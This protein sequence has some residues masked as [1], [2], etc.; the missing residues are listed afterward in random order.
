[1]AFADSFAE[2]FNAGL[3]RGLTQYNVAQEER[4]RKEQAAREAEAHALRMEEAR[5]EAAR[6]RRVEE[7]RGAI[8]TAAMQGMPTG[9]VPALGEATTA[10]TYLG[11][12]GYGQGLPA[13]QEMA[14]DYQREMGRFG[15]PQQA[16]QYDTAGVGVRQATD[17][18]INRLTQQYALAANDVNAF[19]ALRGEAADMDWKDAFGERLKAFRTMT[20][21][22][23]KARM[24][25]LTADQTLPGVLEWEPGKTDKDNKYF[26]LTPDRSMRV[27]LS[28][29]EVAQLSALEEMAQVDPVRAEQEIANLTGK[30]REVG[31][32]V[33]ELLNQQVNINNRAAGDVADAAAKERQQQIT[34]EYYRGLLKRGAGGGGGAES[35]GAQVQLVNP[36]TGQIGLA[37]TNELPKDPTTGLR[38][39]PAGWKFATQ[40]P[41]L[42]ANDRIARIT[43]VYEQLA[44]NPPTETV[45][46]KQVPV[47]QD[48][49]WGMATQQVDRMLGQGGEP[50]PLLTPEV[51]QRMIDLQAAR[52][53]QNAPAPAPAASTGQTVFGPLTP[54]A[55]VE[56]EARAGNPAAIRYLQQLQANQDEL[57]RSRATGLPM[58]AP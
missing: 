16:P 42:S 26:F 30:A 49:L 31:F 47:S 56:A 40:R 2:S 5:R 9:A 32:K 24:E 21:E 13:V 17:R 53:Q 36:T 35:R 3:G 33:M 29:S 6:A 11:R 48:R 12:A 15:L 46:G 50:A 45:N 34:E 18:D 22:Q 58:V 27:P 57:T 1:M 8:E 10:D 7:A 41:E 4:R 37:Y 44:A 51:V 25:Q 43:G 23:R 52:T 55:V 38:T 39:P 20:P 28:E 19:R 54:R 14:G